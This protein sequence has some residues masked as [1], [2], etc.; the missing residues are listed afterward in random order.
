MAALFCMVSCSS[1]KERKLNGKIVKDKQGNYYRL[2]ANAGNTMLIEQL[3][4]EDMEKF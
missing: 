4:P 3:N 1:E 2:K